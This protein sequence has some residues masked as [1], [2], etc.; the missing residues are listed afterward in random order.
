MTKRIW[1]ITCPLCKE[2]RGHTN[3][4]HSA[5]ELMDD[6]LMVDENAGQI[7]LLCNDC[8]VLYHNPNKEADLQGY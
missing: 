8:L 1:T 5:G 4:K 2:S 3:K 6:S 7:L